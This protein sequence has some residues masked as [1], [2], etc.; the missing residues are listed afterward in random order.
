M[1]FNY[2]F[3]QAHQDCLEDAGITHDITESMT[4]QRFRWNLN[5]KTHVALS[6]D[7]A[8]YL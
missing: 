7:C 8:Q 5:S 2:T 4:P 1:D 6:E 3:R